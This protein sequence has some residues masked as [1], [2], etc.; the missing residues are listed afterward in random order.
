MADVAAW[1]F[2][3]WSLIALTFTRQMVGA[4]LWWLDWIDRMTNP[5]TRGRIRRH[6][7]I[8]AQFMRDI[9]KHNAER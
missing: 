1:L 8:V 9:E 7:E 5:R 2:I 3:V 6:N 4:L